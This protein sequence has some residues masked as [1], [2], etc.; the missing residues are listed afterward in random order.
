[1]NDAKPSMGGFTI[2]E[3][4]IVLAIT[5]F[6]LLIAVLTFAG[7][8]SKVEFN[9]SIRDIQSVIQQT[10]NEVGSG[11]YPNGGNVHCIVSGANLDITTSPTELG[12]NSDCIFMGK[13]MQFGIGGKDPQQYN[14]FALA[15]IKNNGGDITNARPQIVNI[16]SSI[17]NAQLHGGITAVKMTY[18]I[19]GTAHNIGAVAFVSGLGDLDSNNQLMSGTQQMS[20][21]PIPNSGQVPN[22]INDVVIGAVKSQI[23]T[24]PVNPNGGV[25]ICFASGGTNQSGLI[26]IGSNGRDVSVKLDIKSTVNCT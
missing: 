18:I 10:I 11:Y 21:I 14:V 7:Q 8:Q 1:M 3:T 26:T 12:T 20:L 19:D 13:V 15:G 9:Q 23:A 16:P 24:A 4:L 17:T 2:V 6:L 22:T 5:G 25:Q